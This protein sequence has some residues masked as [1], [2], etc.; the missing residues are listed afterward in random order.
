MVESHPSQN[1]LTQPHVHYSF[2]ETASEG[3]S[4]SEEDFHSSTHDSLE[5]ESESLAQEKRYQLELQQRIRN[6]EELLSQSYYDMEED[7]LE[8]DSLE[9]NA[10]SE[11]EESDAE[12][13]RI[14]TGR[15]HG[16]QDCSNNP[17]KEEITDRYSELRYNPNWKNE[18]EGVLVKFKNSYPEDAQGSSSPS[19]SPTG[20]PSQ[21]MLTAMDHHLT[22]GWQ[23]SPSVSDRESLSSSAPPASVS[24]RSCP[25]PKRREQ[26]GEAAAACLYNSSSGIY[27]SGSSAPAKGFKQQRSKKDF[28]GKNKVTLGLASQQKNSYLQLY[29]KK[30]REGHPGEAHQSN[31][32]EMGG[33]DPSQGTPLKEISIQYPVGA[34]V[35]LRGQHGRHHNELESENTPTHSS[36]SSKVPNLEPDSRGLLHCRLPPNPPVALL[37]PSVAT[38]IQDT[39]WHAGPVYL[40]CQD[41]QETSMNLTFVR[42]PLLP[43]PYTNFPVFRLPRTGENNQEVRQNTENCSGYQQRSPH[44]CV[45][46]EP[47]SLPG[48]GKHRDP[49]GD[50]KISS[51]YDPGLRQPVDKG[52][53][54]WNS[55]NICSEDIRSSHVS[56]DPGP[57]QPLA[58]NLRGAPSPTEQL[59]QAAERHHQ[60]ISQLAD[61]QLAS[62]LPPVMQRGESDSRLNLESSRESRPYLSRSNS[63]GYLLQREK[64]NERKE[65]E[66]RKAEKFKQQ[67]E[68]AK[69]IKEHNIKNIISARKPPPRSEN[70]LVVCRQKALEYAKGIPKPKIVLAKSSEQD[71]KDEKV[72]ARTLNGENLPPIASLE[73]LQSRH[74]RE[75][76]VVAAFKTFHI[77]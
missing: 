54:S 36:S 5:S 9:E 16:K 74:E 61:D 3:L 2:L 37:W 57:P 45:F 20:S 64:Q 53:S 46:S 60:E 13:A 67:K 59:I 58:H 55:R 27:S 35:E 14:P 73:S 18:G 34:P 56:G 66:N 8:E 32:P 10:L 43:S 71:P 22:E 52:H 1:G 31:G 44:R 42:N 50:K 30:Q 76:Q 23:D 7:S 15:N 62:M 39:Q 47:C 51:A 69:Q 70:K 49:L 41:G 63:E 28:I 12:E 77:V 72:L 29:S 48:H 21:D 40:V 33:T 11:T 38:G 24:D 6:G 4:L 19:L 25:S 17:S 68:Y 65:R 75:K 26:D